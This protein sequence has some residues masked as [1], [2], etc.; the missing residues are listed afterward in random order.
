[1]IR[2]LALVTLLASVAQ[3]QPSQTPPPPSPPEEAQPAPPPPPEPPRVRTPFDQG[4]F[5]FSAGAGSQSA[6]GGRYFG[7]AAGG[8]YFVLDGVGIDLGGGFQWGDGPNIGRVT[9]GVRYVVQPLVGKF[10]LIPYV[11]AFYSHWFISSTYPDQDAVGGRAGLLY[12]SGS[13]V[14]GLGAVN[15][16]IVSQCTMDC[17]IWYPDLTIAIAF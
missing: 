2:A 5:G 11:G 14:L 3:A 17:S 1:M 8:S 4:R 10:P 13:M 9:P 15:E 12:V 6:F 16:H 7:I